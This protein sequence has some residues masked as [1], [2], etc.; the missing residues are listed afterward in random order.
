[1]FGPSS[2]CMAVGRN[3]GS[4]S[5]KFISVEACMLTTSCSLE[6]V[7][8]YQL[9]LVNDRNGTPQGSVG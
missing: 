9:R 1:M 2:V 4:Q 3:M 6:R 8:N 5:K 7:N